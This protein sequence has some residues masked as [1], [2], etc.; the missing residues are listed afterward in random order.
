[1]SQTSAASAITEIKAWARE[2]LW[3]GAI[4]AAGFAVVH[5]LGSTL[6]GVGGGF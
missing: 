1:M 4:T 3:A 6:A 2:I 5:S